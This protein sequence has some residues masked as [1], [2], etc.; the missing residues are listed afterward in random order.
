MTDLYAAYGLGIIALIALGS[1]GC[2]IWT[3]VD[4]IECRRGRRF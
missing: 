1:I 4:A 3:V 2:L